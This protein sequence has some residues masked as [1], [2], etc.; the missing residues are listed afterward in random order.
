MMNLDMRTILFSSVLTNFVCL[1]VIILLWHQSRVRY[2]G[3]SY[4]IYDFAFQITGLILIMLRG[5]IPDWVSMLVSNTLIVSGALLGFIGL[6]HFVCK[7]RSQLHNYI[8]LIIFLCV[9]SY[10]TLVHPYLVMRSL[11][12]TIVLLLITIQCVWLLIWRVGPEMRKLTRWVGYVFILY[13]LVGLLRVDSLIRHP[14][15]TDYFHSGALEPLALIANQLLFII[16][17]YSL[18]LMVNQRLFWDIRTQEDKYSKVFHSAPYAITLSRNSDGH[19][20]DVNEGFLNITGY[21]YDEVIGKSTIDMHLWDRQEDRT[22]AVQDLLEH[23]SM[24]N[25]EITFRKKSGEPLIGLISANTFML[26]DECVFLSNINDITDRKQAEIALAES[27]RLFHSAFNYAAIGIALVSLDGQYFQVNRS[28]CEMLGYSEEELLQRKFQDIT[29]HEDLDADT[30]SMARLLAGESNSMCIHKRFLH[31]TGRIIWARRNISLVR[32]NDGVPLYYVSQVEDI[33]EMV[34][35]EKE[36]ESLQQQLMQVSKMES[37]GRLAGGVAHDF[38]NMLGVILGYTELAKS[39]VDPDD[40]LSEDL[41]EIQAAAEHSA[42]LTRQLLAFARKQTAIRKV[43]NL[44]ETVAAGLGMLRR[45]VGEDINLFWQP[46]TSLWPVYIDPAQVN[47][48][49]TNLCINSRDAIVNHGQITISSENKTL[50]E[51]WCR[52]HPDASPGE[53]VMLSVSDDGCGMSPDMLSEIFEPFFTTKELGKGIGLGLASVYG[54]V[55]QN[56]GCITVSSEPGCGTSFGI[57]L[58]RHTAI[59]EA[60]SLKPEPAAIR[61]SKETVLI[62]ED[63]PA[64]LTLGQRMLEQQGYIVLAAG[65]PAEAIRI[66]ETQTTTID[67]LLTDIVMPE[68]NG[69]ELAQMLTAR[70]PNIKKVFMSGYTADVISERGLLDADVTF[71]QKPFSVHEIVTKVREELDA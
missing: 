45:L 31:S 4:L 18:V 6:E 54:A 34:D 30:A 47:Q 43:L 36:K 63:E 17:T 69:R 28:L 68:M 51:D 67:L 11:N 65:T 50:N 49:L 26:D 24:R 15:A 21:Q 5:H 48:I 46:G 19:I 60:E 1:V 44:N 32:D 42:E 55:K 3:L 61:N 29:Y 7:V 9:H 35:A 38:N 33:T 53:Y 37:I 58:P 10:F 56:N 16:L 23:G 2:K 27:Q 52:Q 20:L 13:S 25:R 8:F 14:P 22:Q 12:I 66:A 62:V 70:Y 71:V 59:S 41:S 40:S 64:M 57:Y 39:K